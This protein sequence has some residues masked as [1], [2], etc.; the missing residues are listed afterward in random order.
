[1]DISNILSTNSPYP[2]IIL[3]ASLI[4]LILIIHLF[5]KQ[6]IN[7][8]KIKT[9][10]NTSNLSKLET[11]IIL[12]GAVIAVQITAT[13]IVTL[14]TTVGQE[15]TL[16]INT[17]LI[18]LITYILA[19]TSKIILHKWNQ[20]L[21]KIRKDNAHEEIIPLAKSIINIILSIVAIFIILNIWGVEVAGLLASVGIIG[22]ILSFAFKDTLANIFGGIAL[23]MDNSFKKG[24]LI[25]L[26]DGEIGYIEEINL[27]STRIKNFDAQEVLIPNGIMANMKIKNYAHPSETLRI[28]IDVAIAYG[29]DV[30]KF[31]KV[32]NKLLDKEKILL[33]FP[34]HK[35]FFEKLADYSL[36]FKIT[37]F[38]KNYHDFYSI[39]SD[40]TE[41][42]YAELR[43]NNIKIPF[44]TRTLY[45]EKTK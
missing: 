21:A 40:M 44:P 12:M 32:I 8:A 29:S 18:I 42:I 17:L 19:T 37:F 9:K 20:D 16:L 3:S 38:I 1:M 26:N 14:Y 35:I 43:K 13:K 7:Y 41:K 25:E 31:K 6:I 10:L 22:I 2:S 45:M 27:R 28:K 34:K 24:D 23:I 15:I 4:I 5:K 11:P 36:N 33:K 39:K 30:V